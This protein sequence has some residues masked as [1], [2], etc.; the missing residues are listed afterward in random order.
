MISA[1]VLR[2]ILTD[3]WSRDKCRRHS[4]RHSITGKLISV[5]ED[6]LQGK[7]FI[8][9]LCRPDHGLCGCGGAVGYVSDRLL[10]SRYRRRLRCG[11]CQAQHVSADVDRL[12]RIFG[13]SGTVWAD[14]DGEIVFD[15]ENL[16]QTGSIRVQNPPLSLQGAGVVLGFIDTGI[17]YELD[18]FRREDGSSRIMALWD[19][20]IQDGSR[21][22][23][24]CMVRSIPEHRSTGR[25]R[26]KN[27]RFSY[28]LPIPTD[29]AHRWLPWLRAVF[30]I[31][32]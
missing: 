5:L 1:A 3:C 24:F 26:R 20:T 25:C 28:P 14:A 13:D 6:D 15:P 27:R 17:R 22:K 11:E 12:L 9:R 29:M 2:N 23:V 21:R 18:V 16:A 4:I 7:D 19:Q 10:L 31:R 30:W 32:G 8:K